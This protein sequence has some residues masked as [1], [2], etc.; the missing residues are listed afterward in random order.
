MPNIVGES[1]TECFYK[2]CCVFTIDIGNASTYT[3][4]LC[5]Y[6]ES[7]IRHVKKSNTW[8]NI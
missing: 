7:L 4:Y 2:A 5:N 3:V 6:E 8:S 1:L